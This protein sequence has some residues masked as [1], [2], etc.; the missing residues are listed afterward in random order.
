MYTIQYEAVNSEHKLQSVDC[1]SRQKLLIHL[2]AFPRP[3]VAVYEQG[4]PITKTMRKE[5]AVYGGGLS[6]DAREFAGV[7]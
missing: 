4:T 7:I 1:K 2:A 6:R 5:L 3:I